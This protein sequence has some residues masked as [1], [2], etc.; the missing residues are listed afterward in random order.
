VTGLLLVV[1]SSPGDMFTGI[2]LE[3]AHVASLDD[4]RL[5]VERLERPEDAVIHCGFA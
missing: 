3:R 5:V 2:V 1:A 4:G